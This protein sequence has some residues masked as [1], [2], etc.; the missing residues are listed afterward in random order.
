MKLVKSLC[1]NQQSLLETK[2][3]YDNQCDVVCDGFGGSCWRRREQDNSFNG[4][5]EKRRLG[6]QA[7]SIGVA[8]FDRGGGLVVVKGGLL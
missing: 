3:R 6:C 2:P 5:Q 7:A 4:H 1:D 8:A